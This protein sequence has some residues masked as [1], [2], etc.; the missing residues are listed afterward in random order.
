MSSSKLDV[1][2]IKCPKCGH[3]L[4][5]RLSQLKANTDHPCPVCGTTLR[6][7]GDGFQSTGKSLSDAEKA[8]K[9]LGRK[10]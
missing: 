1:I 3:K 9:N 2:D 4:K 7:E 10:R 5:K 8:I 6:I